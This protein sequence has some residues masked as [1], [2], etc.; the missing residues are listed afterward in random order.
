M[1]LP[2]CPL[3]F[4]HSQDNLCLVFQRQV[5]EIGCLSGSDADAG[6]FSAN[7]R[8]NGLGR[9]ELQRKIEVLEEVPFHQL[10]VDLRKVDSCCGRRWG[11]VQMLGK[12]LDPVSRLNFLDVIDVIRA[13]KLSTI[14]CN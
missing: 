5:L 10:L 14:Y 13:E 3:A 1:P 2:P 7:I 4:R 12:R 11:L 6:K 9:C 8:F